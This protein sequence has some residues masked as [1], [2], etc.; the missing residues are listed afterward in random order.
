MQV[1]STYT[2]RGLKHCMYFQFTVQLVGG[3]GYSTEV[4]VIKLQKNCY[5]LLRNTWFC[6]RIVV[7]SLCLKSVT[8][9]NQL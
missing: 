5:V 7:K 1:G 2:Q 3:G 9:M 4:K 8:E 6:K